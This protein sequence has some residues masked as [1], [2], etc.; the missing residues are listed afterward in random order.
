M[1]AIQN[2]RYGRDGTGYAYLEFEYRGQPM[3]ISAQGLK[4]NFVE[5]G[6]TWLGS[7]PAAGAYSVTIPPNTTGDGQREL[8]LDGFTND[9]DVAALALRFLDTINDENAPEAGRLD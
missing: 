5:K 1:S 8:Q 9:P 7:T 6:F 2:A 3:E 4:R